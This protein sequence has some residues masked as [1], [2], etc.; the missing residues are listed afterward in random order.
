MSEL[1]RKGR[2]ASVRKDVVQFTSSIKDDEKILKHVIN[3][4][5][6]HVIMLIEKSIIHKDE[7]KKILGAL[8]HLDK[9]IK[10]TP[11][12]EDVHM[13][14]EEHVINTVGD[15]IGGNLNLAKSRN[16]QVATAIRMELREE[17]LSLIE[18]T[19][20]LQEALIKKSKEHVE[21]IIPGYTHL[22]PAQPITFAHYL[23]AQFDAL[24]RGLKRFEESY[25]RVDLC[26]M[27]AGALATTSFPISRARVAELLG[28]SGVLENSLDAVSTRDFLLEALAV[29]SI[30]AVD[31]TRFAED[32]IIWSTMEFGTV[33][34]PDEFASTSSIMPQKKN[35]DVLEVIRAKMSLVLGD[36]VACVATLKALPSS[37]NMDFQEVTPKVWSSLDTTRDSLIMLSELVPNLAVTSSKMDEPHL[38]FLTSTELANMLVRNHNLSFRTAHKIVGALVK[39]Q[40][41]QGKSLKDVTPDLLAEVSEKLLGFPLSV[42]TREII[43][44]IDPSIFVRS[45]K[46]K[47]GPSPEEVKRMLETRKGS[48]AL[49]KEWV[50]GRKRVVKEAEANLNLLVESWLTKVHD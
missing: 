46:A 7:G 1:L 28:F 35:P 27:G 6:A 13:A 17:L 12:L 31:L 16:D 9:G 22:Q 2:L 47:G 30:M 42:G 36:Y 4:N 19:I 39:L 43:E 10:L 48:L 37:Y 44:A 21:T 32:L 33:E 24:Q 5:K 26:P 34:L 38:S 50:S 25:S 14:I 20:R 49:S 18:A 15:D 8:A 23:L 45:H 3:I 11:E 41:G 29:L 40:I